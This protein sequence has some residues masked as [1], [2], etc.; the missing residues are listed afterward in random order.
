MIIN[1]SQPRTGIIDTKHTLTEYKHL[2]Y[3]LIFDIYLP[4][5]ICSLFRLN[6]FQLF[7]SEIA[8]EE[9]YFHCIKQKEPPSK[10]H[11]M[12]AANPEEHLFI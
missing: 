3:S 9:L 1:I 2:Q 4:G 7:P 5:V 11:C 8:G 12:Q 6:P 10:A